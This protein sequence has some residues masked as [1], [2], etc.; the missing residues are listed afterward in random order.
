[1]FAFD[2]RKIKRKPTNVLNPDLN[3]INNDIVSAPLIPN[4]SSIDTEAIRESLMKES[5]RKE[6]NNDIITKYMNKHLRKKRYSF[7]SK[8]C[9]CLGVSTTKAFTSEYRAK[10]FMNKFYEV[11]V[12]KYLLVTNCDV[13][14]IL[15]N[16][17]VK[18]RFIYNIYNTKDYNKIN[19]LDIFDNNKDKG[20]DNKSLY[21][22]TLS[23]IKMNF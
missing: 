1:M 9:C 11:E 2:T 20:L 21:L 6:N 16:Q 7:C 23:N 10:L 15:Y 3:A 8:F 14:C 19:D 22:E 4:E 5:K 17:F 18:P 13:S 12:L